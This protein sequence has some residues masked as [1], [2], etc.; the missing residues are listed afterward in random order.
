MSLC[1]SLQAILDEAKKSDDYWIDSAKLDFSLAI[2][3]KRRAVNKSYA[4][5]ARAM[6]KSNAYI[7]KIFRGDAN[8]TI[9]SMVKLARAVGGNISIQVNND[10]EF[11]TSKFKHNK[12]TKSIAN[13]LLLNASYQSGYK[14]C[15]NFTHSFS[16]RPSSDES[17]NLMNHIAEVITSQRINLNDDNLHPSYLTENNE[18]Q[19]KNSLLAA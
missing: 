13:E 2:E 10:I 11:E 14:T 18:I 6:G 3:E 4:D 7:S 8:L 19:N 5:I 17:I 9:E 16:A 12:G 15:K 1:K